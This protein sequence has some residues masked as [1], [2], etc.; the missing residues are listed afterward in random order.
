LDLGTWGQGQGVDYT[1]NDAG[2]IITLC[3]LHLE[4][5]AYIVVL[6]NPYFTKAIIDGETGRASYT[7]E[8]VPPGNYILR[9]WHKKLKMYGKQAEITIEKGKTTN[10]DIVI[11][12]RKYAK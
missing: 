5:A 2:V 9:A 11:T 7:I 4:M 3:N 6:D 12:K 8:N 10:L 1:F